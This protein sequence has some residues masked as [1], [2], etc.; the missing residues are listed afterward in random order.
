MPGALCLGDLLQARGFRNVFMGGAYLSFSGKG[1]FFRDHGYQE[2]YGMDEWKS[3]GANLRELNE[4]GLY[5]SDLFRRAKARV[6]SL[7]ASGQPF[8]LTL[9]TL[10]THNP[11][12]F[13][14]P[15]CHSRGARD[16]EGIVSCTGEQLA[17]FVNF[18]RDRGYLD[19]TVVVIL[20]DHLAAPNP[21]YEKLGQSGE[22]HIFNLFLSPQPLVKNTDELFHFDFFP[23]LSEMI[24][25][26]VA[27]D[28]LGLGYSAVFD[29]DVPKPKDRLK[30][31]T[32]P[33]LSGSA[34][35][36]QLWQQP[37]P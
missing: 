9:L 18:M 12:G 21:A 30:D 14:S 22:R 27:G 10:D 24:G 6:A 1:A 19:N 28:R 29:S 2:V 13:M 5:D 32:F 16:F 33:T 31:L 3:A 7:H 8:N 20:G 35:Y 36:N 23:T 26:T 34:A 25:L 15:H 17:D 4:W 37:P 11:H